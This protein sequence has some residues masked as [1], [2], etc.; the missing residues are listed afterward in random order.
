MRSTV[1]KIAL[2]ALLPFSLLAD[3]RQDMDDVCWSPPVAAAAKMPPITTGLILF[4]DATESAQMMMSGSYCTNWLDKSGQ[5]NHATAALSYA[6]TSG[7]YHGRSC[8]QAWGTNYMVLTTPIMTSTSTIFL[9]AYKTAQ[10][11]NAGLLWGKDSA[12]YIVLPDAANTVGAA[13]TTHDSCAAFSPSITG[14]NLNTLTVRRKPGTTSNVAMWAG[15]TSGTV[16]SSGVADP[17]TWK[18]LFYYS[19]DKAFWLKGGIVTILYYSYPLSDADVSTIQDW[20][21]ANYGE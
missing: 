7:V 13:Y 14:S 18:R 9:V 16:A 11:Y 19:T 17:D 4:L 21:I 10:L 8:L 12:P 5:G 6:P 2:L 20:L 15:K 1:C 3:W